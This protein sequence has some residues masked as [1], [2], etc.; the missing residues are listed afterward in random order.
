MNNIIIM[1]F[2][3]YFLVIIGIG[4]ATSRTKMSH[5]VFLLGGK[6]LPGWALAFSERATGESAWLLLGFTGFVFTTGLA[7]IWV[8]AGIASGIIFSWLVLARR[9]MNEAEKYNVLTLPDY[10]AVKFGEK[11]NVIRWLATIL[12]ASFFSR[13]ESINFLPLHKCNWGCHRKAW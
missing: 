6:K 13:K 8:A 2:F 1:E 12:I 3:L 10:L 5:S 11:A 9:F 7:G 4:Y